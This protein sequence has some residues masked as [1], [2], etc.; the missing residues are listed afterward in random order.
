VAFKAEMDE[1]KG[2][3]SAKKA[4]KEKGVDAICLN[5][6]SKN[7]FGSDEN[8]IVFITEDGEKEIK[9]A[10]K[11]EIAKKIVEFSKELESD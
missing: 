5:Y 9:Q 4:L 6:I 8:E 1:E 11:I 3:D 10:S 2:K 7:S